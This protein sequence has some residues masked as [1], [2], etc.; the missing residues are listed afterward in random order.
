MAIALPRQKLDH[1]DVIGE[2]RRSAD[3][4]VEVGR[5]HQHF[6]EGLLKLLSGPEIVKRKDQGGTGA[7]LLELFGLALARCF[8]LNIDQLASGGSC[9]A[10]DV[11]LRNDRAA[12][13][14]PTGNPPAGRDGEGSGGG[15][16]EAFDFGERQT[17]LGKV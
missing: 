2:S 15:L 6:L 9:F 5:I 11:Q 17:R 14:A 12:E 7:Q 16:E 4:L 1:G 10:Q 13:L 3:D 8:E